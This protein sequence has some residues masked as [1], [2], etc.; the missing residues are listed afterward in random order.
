MLEE[1]VNEYGQKQIIENSDQIIKIEDKFLQVRLI[2]TQ[3]WELRGKREEPEDFRPPVP[4]ARF[5]NPQKDKELFYIVSR[6]YLLELKKK[7]KHRK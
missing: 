7:A 2:S 3:K 1:C 6:K 5:V 4:R